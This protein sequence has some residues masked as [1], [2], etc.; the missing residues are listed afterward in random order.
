MRQ[1]NVFCS[2]HQQTDE[3]K[4]TADI[5]RS[6]RHG[7]AFQGFEADCY[8]NNRRLMLTIR[9]VCFLVH[10]SHYRVSRHVHG[11]RTDGLVDCNP[12]QSLEIIIA[13]LFAD[14]LRG[15]DPDFH[16][17]CNIK[18]MYHRKWIETIIPRHQ[19]E[20]WCIMTNS[21]ALCRMLVK[22][23]CDRQTDKQ[24]DAVIV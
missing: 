5:A 18:Q 23:R 10:G 13:V 4:Q 1:C 19:Q 6:S 22:R 20:I 2:W 16:Q 11:L 9:E 3:Y 15:A 7:T 14:W 8:L 12:Q 21:G 17:K 24:I